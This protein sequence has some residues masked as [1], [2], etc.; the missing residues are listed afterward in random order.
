MNRT[1]RRNA[2]LLRDRSAEKDGAAAVYSR[3]LV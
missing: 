2:T 3:R 1:E